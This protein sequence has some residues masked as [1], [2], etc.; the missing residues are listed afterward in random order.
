MNTLFA[1]IGNTDLK[2]STDEA[3]G[4]GPIAH[5]LSA[6]GFRTAHLL[7]NYETGRAEQYLAWL[8]QRAG[9][10]SLHLHPVR[11]ESP[12][13]FAAIYQAA[14]AVVQGWQEAHPDARPTFHLSPGTPAMAAVWI[15]LANGKFRAELIET[16]REAGQ[17]D[18]R[19]PFNLAAEFVADSFRAADARLSRDSPAITHPEFDHIVGNSP[20]LLRAKQRARKAAIRSLPVLIEGASGTGKELFARAIHQASPR[21]RQPFIAINCGA[22]PADLA[23]SELFGHEKGA[24]T[25][26]T[27][28]RAGH[29]EQA[30]GGTLFLDEIGELPKPLQVKLLRVLQEGEITRVGSSRA[31]PVDVRIIAATHCNLIDSVARGLFREDLFYRLA[32]A[33]LRLPALREREGDLGMLIDHLWQLVGAENRDTPGYEHKNISIGA[34]KILL[35]HHWPGNVRELLNTLRR[36]SIWAEGDSISPED[37][38]DALLE[39]P[40]GGDGNTLEIPASIAQG[41][42]LKELIGKIRDHYISQALTLSGGNKTRAAKLLGLA[43][44]QT[45]N[46]WMKD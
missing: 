12:T 30:S 6:R 32:V 3:N 18:V 25:G 33:T 15:M 2:A 46:N 34:R 26:A 43:N 13:D 37:A 4:P 41:I 38:A 31:I 22:I 11:L 21:A 29:F 28:A 24:F 44:Y 23:E 17:R 5:A 45:L 14:R 10:V 27:V 40:A 16:S 8:R 7:C 20:A 39:H 9:A 36:I 19:F 42:D 35:Q 1:W